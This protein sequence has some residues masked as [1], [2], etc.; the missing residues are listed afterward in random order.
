VAL[1][2]RQVSSERC[3]RRMAQDW[4]PF[5]D[6]ADEDHQEPAEA[7]EC[8]ALVTSVLTMRNHE[9][10]HETP[11]Q[12]KAAL[13]DTS[14][15][16]PESSTLC[17]H[18]QPEVGGDD[19]GGEPS[20][21]SRPAVKT[22]PGPIQ[23]QCPS[24]AP[25]VE[26]PGR[27]AGDLQARPIWR[28]KGRRKGGGKGK[29]A[30][31][32][33]W[34]LGLGS[35]IQEPAKELAEGAKEQQPEMTPTVLEPLGPLSKAREVESAEAESTRE[36]ESPRDT[37]SPAAKTVDQ[38]AS[39][40]E[41][42]TSTGDGAEAHISNGN[43]E[44]TRIICETDPNE[45]IAWRELFFKLGE[46]DEKPSSSSAPS[47]HGTWGEKGSLARLLRREGLEM[48]ERSIASTSSFDVHPAEPAKPA[49][50]ALG[51]GFF[52]RSDRFGGPRSRRGAG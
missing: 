39:Y 35:A 1:T 47:E 22:A 32:A 34:L 50:P 10:E 45:V 28:S 49:E 33:A 12:L 9:R 15:R 20:L 46:V 37:D 29:D 16:S 40:I 52:R 48:P 38:E 4:D 26:M 41:G 3:A 42:S 2:G 19:A 30:G 31:H 18:E 11:L 5:A 21:D 24:P 44:E 14:A 27:P 8:Q 7:A 23:G 36:A 25:A 13:D 51:Q 17:A 6:P 43:A